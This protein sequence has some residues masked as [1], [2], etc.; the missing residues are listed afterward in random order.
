MQAIAG[1]KSDNDDEVGD[2]RGKPKPQESIQNKDSLPKA[3][4]LVDLESKKRQFLGHR[5]PAPS[6]KAQKTESSLSRPVKSTLLLPPQLS[7]RS[8]VVTED[9][10]TLFGKKFTS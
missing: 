9:L 6:S 7:G 3:S 8:N 2:R 10:S 1:Y 5:Q 4:T